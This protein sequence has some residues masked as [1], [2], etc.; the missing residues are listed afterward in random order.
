MKTHLTLL[1]ALAGISTAHAQAPGGVFQRF[2]KNSDGKVTTDELPNQ[3]AFARFDTN[4]DGAITLEEYNAVTGG[5]TPKPA[6]PTTPTKPAETPTVPADAVFSGYDKNSDNKVTKDELANE[7]AFQ[8]Y[9]LDKDGAISLAEYNK[10]SGK[11]APTTPTTPGADGGVMAAQIENMIK[12]VDKNADGQITKDEAGDAP[13]FTRLDQ[14]ANG[15]ISAEELAMMRR[16]VA[17]RGGAG[18]G[19]GGRGMPSNAPSI[20]PEDVQKVT[21]GPEVLKP[22]EVGIGRMME[23]ISFTTLDGQKA[24]LSGFKSKKGLVIL[25][26]SATCPVSKRYIPSVAKMEKELAAQN[27]ALLLVNPFASE[28]A[29]EIK[30]QLTEAGVTA[31]YAHDKEK[32]LT[33]LLQART[34]TEVFL[35]DAMR[36]LVYRGAFDDQYGINYNL[37]APKHRYLHDAI[38]AFLKNEKPAIQATAAPGCE[39]DL[40]DAPKLAASPVTYHRDVARIL[41]QNCVTCHRDGGIA[42]FALDDIEEVKDRAKVIK[43][44]VSEGTMPPWFAAVEKD[45]EKNPWANDCSLS[46]K[47]KADLFAWLDSTGR[48]LGNV[49]DAPAKRSYPAEWSI[50]TPDLIIPLSR[51][52]DIKAD[53]FM[54]YAFD[55][56]DTDIPEDKW[57]TAY[58]ILPSE[59]DVVHHVI[60]QVHEKGA[61]AR[62]REEGTGGYWAIYVPGNGAN[63]YPQGFARKIPAGARVSFQIHYTPSGKAKKERLRMGLVFAKTPPQYEVKTVA[64]ANTRISIPPGAERH[65]ETKTQRV[66]FD[67]PVTSFMPH[68]HIR[69]AGFKYEVTYTDGKTETL[70]DI[71]RY[72]FN[73]Q[74][75]YDYKQPKLIP[76]GSTIKIT[77]IYN[78]SASNKANPDPTKLVKWGSQTVDEMMLGYLEYF[79]PV[80]GSVAAN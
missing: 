19:N 37:E 48:P 46:A 45:A 31:P 56:V 75:R 29:D 41:Q 71:P 24:S 7:T 27:V 40:A 11:T 4:K 69:G 18:P 2:D 42:P 13:W 32:K 39:L 59:R 16:I 34:T 77:A 64:V 49:A 25:M 66:P 65:V 72:D 28:T 53:G 3:Q 33:A 20:T 43:R 63:I 38:T 78:N 55:V 51:A 5:T 62:D 67:M 73:W 1:I 74:L 58:E 50:G 35:L 22:G 80:G 79:L 23:D 15:I 14:D 21:S 47:D 52:Y 10:V 54:P 68:L 70:L 8:R 9:D 36:T 60:V 30:A 6:T 61:D 44:V 76:R 17:Q 12:A 57:V 26:T